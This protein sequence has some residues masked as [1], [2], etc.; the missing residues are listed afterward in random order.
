MKGSLVI[1]N[2]APAMKVTRSGLYHIVL[3]LNKAGDLDLT[4][5]AQI[6]IAPVDWNI[7]GINGDWG[8]TAM[9]GSDFNQKTMTWTRTYETTNAGDFKFAHGGGWK[10]EFCAVGKLKLGITV[11]EDR[12]AGADQR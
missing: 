4:G 6:I 3:D 9:T 11:G 7:R 8:S 2:D 1:G 12:A 5:G 10:S